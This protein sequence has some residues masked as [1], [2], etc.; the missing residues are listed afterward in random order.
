MVGSLI[1]FAGEPR[2]GSSDCDSR[3]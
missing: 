2:S 3:A 1:Y